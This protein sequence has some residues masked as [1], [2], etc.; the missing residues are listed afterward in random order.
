MSLPNKCDHQTA[1]KSTL[2]LRANSKSHLK[3]LMIYVYFLLIQSVL[4]VAK[5]NRSKIKCRN[6]NERDLKMTYTT[7]YY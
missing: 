7:H 6:K 2:H 5:I 1:H 4:A 3:P